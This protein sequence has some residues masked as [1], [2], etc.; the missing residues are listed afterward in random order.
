MVLIERLAGGP[1]RFGQLRNATAGISEKML[2]QTLRGLERDGLVRRES[3]GYSLTDL[4]RSL[5]EPL[6]AVRVWA[7]RHMPEVE[8]ARASF[9]N[10]TSII[11]AFEC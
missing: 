11:D 3:T 6:H 2:T 8:D 10:E 4:G 5:L 7:R 1:K 9:D